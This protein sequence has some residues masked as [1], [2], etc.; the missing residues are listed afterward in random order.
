M[1]TLTKEWLLKTIAELE[2]ERDSVP[3][4]VNED[5]AMALAAMKLALASLEA[6]AVEF[7]PK[8][9]D[10]ALTILGVA[11]PVSKEEFNLESERG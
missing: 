1:S 4:V 2:E 6:E 5:A 8:N 11:L 7:L 9:L 3:D 10:R